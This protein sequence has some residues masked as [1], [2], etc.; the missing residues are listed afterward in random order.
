MNSFEVQ[1]S[2]SLGGA[3]STAH[4]RTCLSIGGASKAT[5]DMCDFQGCS[6]SS[7]LK[8]QNNFPSFDFSL[9]AT[10]EK[11]SGKPWNHHLRSSSCR[12]LDTHVCFS[13]VFEPEPVEVFG[14]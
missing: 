3:H 11:S 2:R 5:C 7:W 1:D 9:E 12:K 13:S 8:V 10:I 14:T 4:D 6:P